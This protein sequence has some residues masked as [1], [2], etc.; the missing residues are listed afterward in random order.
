MI[1]GQ[2]VV[3]N[4]AS[5]KKTNANQRRVLQNMMSSS[6]RVSTLIII[7]FIWSYHAFL[8]EFQV[9]AQQTQ[10]CSLCRDGSTLSEE[11]TN[12]P[13][14]VDGTTCG[15]LERRARQTLDETDA[16]CGSFYQLIGFATCGCPASQ[17]SENQQQ[18]TPLPFETSSC[19]LCLNGS[20][21][22]P[23]F[24]YDT[25]TLVTCG[26]VQEYLEIYMEQTQ[27]VCNVIQYQA[28]VNCGCPYTLPRNPT[29]S[30]CKNTNERVS[31]PDQQTEPSVK[32]ATCG[33]MEYILAVDIQQQYDS[34]TCTT[35][36][37]YFSPK[38]TCGPISKNQ[39]ENSNFPS[40]SPTGNIIQSNGPTIESTDGS[41]T[42]PSWTPASPVTGAPS[43][44]KSVSPSSSSSM[45]PSTRPSVRPS[46]SPSKQGSFS[47]SEQASSSPSLSQVPSG[48]PSEGP[49]TSQIPSFFPS[50]ILDM[51]PNCTALE[52]GIMPKVDDFAKSLTIEYYFHTWLDDTLLDTS[53]NY[54]AIE[55]TLMEL[56]D[57]RISYI[58]AGCADHREGDGASSNQKVHYVHMDFLNVIPGAICSGNTLGSNAPLNVTCTPMNSNVTI[59]YSD[60]ASMRTRRKLN[61]AEN[62]KA[63]ISNIISQEMPSV[64]QQI[65]GIYSIA[66]VGDSDIVRNVE[67][68]RLTSGTKAAIAVAISCS[69]VAIIAVAIL[70]RR[71]KDTSPE[72]SEIF[73]ETML[74]SDDSISD[75]PTISSGRRAQMT[76]WD[77][78]V[79]ES[80]S[81]GSSRYSQRT[82]SVKASD[83]S[84]GVETARSSAYQL[85]ESSYLPNSVLREL[86]GEDDTDLSVGTKDNDDDLSVD[87][88][89]TIEL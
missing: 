27:Q 19:T 81:E 3:G 74:R 23:K 56:F 53:N 38:C 10:P 88:V 54:K 14:L 59:F 39:I 12:T 22:N 16:Q 76:G 63:Y 44:V 51:K 26:Q 42:R 20:V 75:N 30:L 28:V 62:V 36:Q 65:P 78:S 32:V 43:A 5:M 15:Q 35:L 49:T 21:P 13:A 57:R 55:S 84:D 60:V 17:K 18:T 67:S 48:Y 24:M 8:E 2:A 1:T 80:R 70:T 50:S 52:N 82:H 64:T 40:I 7:V 47:P 4:L 83:A 9:S 69:V 25:S 72:A 77:G 86:L 6:R 45:T 73:P 68:E 58:A 29:C 61:E 85:R 11:Y 37:N 33:I 31:N 87:H 89:D 46:W 41:S 66:I 71:K 34:D 79:T